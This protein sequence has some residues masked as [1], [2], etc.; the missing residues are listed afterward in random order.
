MSKGSSGN[1]K[2]CV[3]AWPKRQT[4]FAA[5]RNYITNLS[6]ESCSSSHPARL[7]ASGLPSQFRPCPHQTLAASAP[8]P[9]H[10]YTKPKGHRSWECLAIPK[11]QITFQRA[12][13]FPE[14]KLTRPISESWDGT[15]QQTVLGHRHRLINRE[16]L[17]YLT[18]DRTKTPFNQGP[19]GNTGPSGLMSNSRD[20]P[21]P[22]GQV[23]VSGRFHS[24]QN[25]R[26]IQPG[27]ASRRFVGGVVP[28]VRRATRIPGDEGGFASAGGRIRGL[29]S[30]L[31]L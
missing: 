14:S 16:V 18:V 17:T 24:Q 5:H 12:P 11:S 27:E 10:T 28:E 31:S 9:L 26:P 3:S 25:S 1:A 7:L 8:I 6:R 20:A 30:E 2:T 15:T 22:I 29:S 4:R 23:P 13:A 19:L 21:G